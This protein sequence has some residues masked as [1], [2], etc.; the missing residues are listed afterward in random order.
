MNTMIR[1]ILVAL[2]L[3]IV[4]VTASTPSGRMTPAPAVVT[5]SASTGAYF[6]YVLLIIM[7]NH[8]LCDILASCGGRATYLSGLASSYGV[9]TNDLYCHVN[10]S[11][12]NYLCLTGGSDFGC[13]ADASPNTIACTQTAWGATN[14]VDRLESAGLTWKG[15]MEDM[16]SNCY[17][18]DSGNY[19][20]RHNPFVYYS[21]IANDATRCARDI[22]AGTSDSALLNDLASELASSNFMW[23]TPNKCNDMHSCSIQQGDTYMSGLVP[24]ILNSTLFKTKRAALYITYDEGCDGCGQPVYTAWAGSLAKTGYLSSFDY[25]HYS[26]LS[27]VEANWNL[28]SLTANDRDAP[29]MAEFF[30]GQPS[31]GASTPPTT[32]F[33]L[34][35]VLGVAIPVAA[36]AIVAFLLLR[37]RK[38]TKGSPAKPGPSEPGSAKSP[39]PGDEGADEDE[40]EI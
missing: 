34:G 4:S 20:V 13:T 35:I 19:V 16:P 17:A 9:A 3:L 6:D 38:G 23:L 27:T 26:F 31:R 24:Q 1:A 22:P 14:I 25:N 30:I 39:T 32:P 18:S 10:P 21:D 37:R 40:W 8:N 36:V 11:L 33:P 29:N 15:Y 2:L 28:A 12:P 5:G 7:E